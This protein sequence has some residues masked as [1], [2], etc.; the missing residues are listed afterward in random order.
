MMT[1]IQTR[2][3]LDIERL[4]VLQLAFYIHILYTSIYVEQQSCNKAYIFYVRI[5]G[6]G[7]CLSSVHWQL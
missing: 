7:E 3:T 5:G 2:P 4:P 6:V 1:K